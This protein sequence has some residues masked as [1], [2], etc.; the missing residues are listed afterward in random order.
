MIH[1]QSVNDRTNGRW[2]REEH[3]KFMLGTFTVI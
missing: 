1:E 2:T 3:D